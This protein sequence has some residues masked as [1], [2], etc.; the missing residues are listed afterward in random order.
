MT[1]HTMYL[2]LDGGTLQPGEFRVGERIDGSRVYTIG[3]LACGH[4]SE[5][6]ET[7]RVLRGGV[8]DR[9]WTCPAQGCPHSEYLLLAEEIA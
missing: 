2:R 4:A 5:L 1:R 9:I 3:C 7:H 8:V 6:P